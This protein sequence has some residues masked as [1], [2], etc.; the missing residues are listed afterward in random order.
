MPGYVE[1]FAKFYCG[2]VQL[3]EKRMRSVELCNWTFT[4]ITTIGFKLLSIRIT[5]NGV[6]L[7]CSFIEEINGMIYLW[8]I[9]TCII[10]YFYWVWCLRVCNIFICQY[11]VSYFCV[12]KVY[13]IGCLFRLFTDFLIDNVGD[14]LRN[15][16]TL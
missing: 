10:V 5:M 3:F 1:R 14:S 15:E 7:S 2:K 6:M 12:F 11:C 8:R 9:W 4:W 16:H 13:F